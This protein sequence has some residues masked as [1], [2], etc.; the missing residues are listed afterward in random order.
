MRARAFT[1]VE[2]LIV[3]GIIAILVAILLP[4]LARARESANRAACLSNLRQ[5]YTAFDIYALNN[6]DEVPLGYRTV[7]KQFNSMIFSTTGGQ[8][9]VLFG[10]LSENSYFKDPRILYC[11]SENNPKFMYNTPDNPWPANGI[12][13]TANIQAGYADRPQQQIPDDLSN[14]PASLQPFTMPKLSK[15]K[16]LAIFADL[17]ASKTRVVTRHKSG[18]NVLY[19]NGGAHWVPL[20]A[21]IQPDASWPDPVTPPVATYNATQDA[22]WSALDRG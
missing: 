5:V 15:F 4:A 9:W 2:L 21:F 11:P 14:V 22:I 13:P 6:H 8:F 12:T 7:S 19:G 20:D 17:T 3:I 18:I 10:L 1:L 16:N